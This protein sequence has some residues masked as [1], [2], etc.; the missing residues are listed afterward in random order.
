MSATT[1]RDLV[2]WQ[3][4]HKLVLMVYRVTETFPRS[5]LFGLTSQM[6]R[7]VVSIPANIVEGFKRT[8]NPR[9]LT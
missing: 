1:F 4:A 5:E 8:S 3:E 7:S 9:S 2:V 6:R